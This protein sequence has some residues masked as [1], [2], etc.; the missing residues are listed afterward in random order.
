MATSVGEEGL[1]G[2]GVRRRPG[3]WMSRGGVRRGVSDRTIQG[4]IPATVAVENRLRGWNI[5]EGAQ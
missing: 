1:T 2:F 3:P 5:L 4:T